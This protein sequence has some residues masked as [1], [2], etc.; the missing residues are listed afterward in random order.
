MNIINNSVNIKGL[1]Y[2]IDGEIIY[3]K[4][5]DKVYRANFTN[6]EDGKL[7]TP[8]EFIPFANKM[9]NELTVTIRRPVDSKGFPIEYST[10]FDITEYEELQIDWKTH[11]EIEAEKNTPKEP[12][13]EERLQQAEDTILYLL[14][15]G[16]I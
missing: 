8:L 3:I 13:L 12:A 4:Y 1:S 15:N 2:K 14:M 10:N 7:N 11:E 9:N 6:F 16:G 5:N